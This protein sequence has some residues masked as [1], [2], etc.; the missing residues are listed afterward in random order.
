M[1]ITI[2]WKMLLFISKF[3]PTNI[4]FHFVCCLQF[5]FQCEYHQFMNSYCTI[6][7]CYFIP[8]TISICSAISLSLCDFCF[9]N[10]LWLFETLFSKQVHFLSNVCCCCCIRKLL[11]ILWC[12]IFCWLYLLWKYCERNELCLRKMGEY[13][14]LFRYIYI[15]VFHIFFGRLFLSFL[16]LSLLLDVAEST[17]FFYFQNVSSWVYYCFK[18]MLKLLSI[19]PKFCCVILCVCV[20][21]QLID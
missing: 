5:Q 9:Y 15:C 7:C 8:V 13:R 2:Y 14:K 19:N 16:L 12:L 6:C 20:Y 3:L 21:S 11:T 17:L 18:W 10:L 4:F 1:I